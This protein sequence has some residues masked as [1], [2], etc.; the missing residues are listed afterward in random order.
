MRAAVYTRYGPPEVLQLREVAKPVPK[1]NEVLIR[2]RATTVNRTDCGFRKPEYGVII[3]PLNGLLRPRKKILG[4]EFAGEIE[5]IGK[6]VKTF[7]PGDPVFGL[8]TISFGAHAEYICQPESGAIA[9]KPVNV[10]YEEA[11]AVCDG[12]TLG[13]NFM[14]KID[15]RNAHE[16][17]INGA[18]GSIGTACVQLAKYYGANI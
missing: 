7:A 14:R 16:I 8:T 12:L 18:S 17:L 1:A 3:R 2:I 15:F 13:M 10:P 6:D 9:I 11:A 5:A 4:S